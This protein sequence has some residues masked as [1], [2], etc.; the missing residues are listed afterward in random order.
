MARAIMARDQAKLDSLLDEIDREFP[1]RGRYRGSPS[2]LYGL[3]KDA[4]RLSFDFIATGFCK[5]ALKR[6]MR[7]TKD[8]AFIPG[9]L[10][11]YWHSP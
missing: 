7:V 5:V 6:G 4:N 11:H 8:S 9:S 10:V 3:G 2:I 1:V